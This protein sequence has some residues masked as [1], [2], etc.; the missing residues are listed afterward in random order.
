MNKNPFASPT[1]RSASTKDTLES[2]ATSRLLPPAVG[3][4]I[5]V[6]LG[7]LNLWAGV[8]LQYMAGQFP[9]N[10]ETPVNTVRIATVLTLTACQCVF[11]NGAVYMLKAKNRRS[12]ILAMQ[13][14]CIPICSPLIILGIPVAIW[15]LAVLN[16]SRV[17]E[18]FQI[19]SKSGNDKSPIG[20]SDEKVSR[21]NGVSA[22]STAQIVGKEC[23]TCCEKIIFKNDGFFCANCRLPQC[24]ACC[25]GEQIC[26]ACGTINEKRG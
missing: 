6:L 20:S 7:L 1:T 16:D 17:K 4:I 18:Y 9:L 23:S 22:K 13:L 11:L 3:M 2:Y 19:N 10:F 8:L 26:P 12:A 14:A 24:L 25:A 21:V 15:A 5:L